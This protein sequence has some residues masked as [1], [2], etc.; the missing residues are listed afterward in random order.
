MTTLPLTSRSFLIASQGIANELEKIK[1][2]VDNLLKVALRLEGKV[3]L[4]AMEGKEAH[5]RFRQ[6]F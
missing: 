2:N 1:M 6:L 4:E 5:I 3:R